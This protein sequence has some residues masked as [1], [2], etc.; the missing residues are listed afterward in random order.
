[1]PRPDYETVDDR[2]HRFK[3]EYPNSR[4]VTTLLHHDDVRVG[5]AC[6]VTVTRVPVP[7]VSNRITTGSGSSGVAVIT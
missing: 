2:L 7:Q 3:Q 5:S 1:M 4:I 6:E